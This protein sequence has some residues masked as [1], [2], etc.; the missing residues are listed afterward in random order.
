MTKLIVIVIYCEE[1]KIIQGY[2][3][4][5]GN[6]PFYINLSQL[7]AKKCNL[8]TFLTQHMIIV[9][10][11]TKLILIISRHVHK[12]CIN[13]FLDSSFNIFQVGNVF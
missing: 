2:L 3:N 4:F 6:T 11:T 13:N 1:Y 5:S 12:I 10:D 9:V 8:I 7:I